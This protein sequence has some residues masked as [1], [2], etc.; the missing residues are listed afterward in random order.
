M[1]ESKNFLSRWSQ[2][3]LDSGDEAVP[4]EPAAPEST[5][6]AE[7]KIAVSP[8]AEFD[9]A[10]LPPIESI[11]AGSDI[12][13]FLQRGVPAGLTRAALRR[14]WSADPAIRDFI[15]LS[16]NAWDFN[17]PDSI[18]GFGTLGL[19]DAKRLAEQFF[20]QLGASKG[21]EASPE[22]RHSLVQSRSVPKEADVEP[23]HEMRP[24]EIATTEP[25]QVLDSQKVEDRPLET[26]SEGQGKVDVAPQYK[27]QAPEYD[28]LASQKRHGKALPK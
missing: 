10:T 26:A 11:G 17:Q 25:G 8:E 18:P 24:A 6:P 3:K 1:N 4:A 14:V 15:G 28:P 2:R 12:R 23:L 16:E 21:T 19:E 13:A 20:D 5:N 27:E 22:N 7:A 9:P